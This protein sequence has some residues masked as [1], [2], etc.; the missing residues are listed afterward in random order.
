MH[1]LV[2]IVLQ[3]PE[4]G[5]LRSWLAAQLKGF[6]T[7]LH[8]T[9]GEPLAVSSDQSIGSGGVRGGPVGALLLG[10]HQ[11]VLLDLSSQ[12]PLKQLRS[13]AADVRPRMMFGQAN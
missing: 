5:S 12:L 4:T 6:R 3:S 9:V 7:N 1:V 10:L 13:F 8:R 11:A 2:W